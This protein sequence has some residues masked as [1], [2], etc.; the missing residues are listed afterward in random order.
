MTT[1]R[2]T[3]LIQLRAQHAAAE[4]ITLLA[5]AGIDA[6]PVKGIV[7][8]RTL[9]R[10]VAERVLTD[11][12][13][14][15]RPE[16]FRRV[17]QVVRGEG[18]PI[19]QLMHAYGNVVF[20]LDG[21]MID[22]ESHPSAP[23]T[24]ALTVDEMIRR[25]RPSDVLGVPHLLPE[26][27]DHAAVLILNVFKDKLVKAFR[28]AVTDVEILPSAPEF[29]TAELVA[30]LGS[31]KALSAAAFVAEWMTDERGIDGWREPAALLRRV[32]PRPSFIARQRWLAS[33]AA[34]DALSLRLHVR[35]S[36]D[37]ALLRARAIVSALLWS[38]EATSRVGDHPHV[39]RTLPDEVLAATPATLKRERRS[40]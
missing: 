32:A 3:W 39:R 36:A 10:D 31:I 11:V 29:R 22:V 8:S 28:W 15:V 6:L 33:H 13:L 34:H 35:S 1:A 30:R 7:T 5:G 20:E 18:L 40:P 12:D 24:S 19:R 38:V 2:D 17:V 23:F 37:S 25:A 14:K 16:D 4:A 26:F 9:Y 27:Y 21:V